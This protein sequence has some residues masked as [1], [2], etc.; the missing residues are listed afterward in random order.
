M[1]HKAWCSI[2]DVLYYFSGSSIKFQGHMGWKIDDLNPIWVRLLGRSQLSN[3]SD[4]FLIFKSAREQGNLCVGRKFHYQNFSRW[5]HY[6]HNFQC[7]EWWNCVQNDDVSVS[8]LEN[9]RMVDCDDKNKRLIILIVIGAVIALII[10][11]LANSFNKLNSDEGRYQTGYQ[12][13][14]SI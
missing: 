6:L 9:L 1:M 8:V 7:S 11:L 2:E 4:L 10:G 3:P 5:L 12:G 13:P 14:V